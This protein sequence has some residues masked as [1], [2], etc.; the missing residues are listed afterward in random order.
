MATKH[1]FS[2]TEIEFQNYNRLVR[3]LLGVRIPV[4][5]VPEGQDDLGY[6]N[7]VPE[8][9]LAKQ[10]PIMKGLRN[11]NKKMFRM[12]VLAHE[13]LHQIFSDFS[14]LRK[15]QLSYNTGIEQRLFCTLFNI[16][17][18]SNIEYY[19]PNVIG[20][21]LL[22]A[23]RY[24][25]QHIYKKS[26][27]IDEGSKEPLTQVVN[28]LIQF[29]DM[30]SVKG[31]FSTPEAR[32]IFGKCVIV[33]NEG[34][35]AKQ[36]SGRCTAAKKMMEITKPLW[37]K[38]KLSE[39][40]Y[41]KLKKETKELLFD[42]G[43]DAIYFPKNGLSREKSEKLSRTSENDPEETSVSARRD[44]LAK[45]IADAIK[46]S[47]SD[48]KRDPIGEIDLSD[49]DPISS[50]KAEGSSD[51]GA[52]ASDASVNSSKEDS[53]GSKIQDALKNAEK[54]ESDDS[55]ITDK[56]LAELE[57]LEKDAEKELERENEDYD[58]GSIDLSIEPSLYAGKYPVYNKDMIP[59]ESDSSKYQSILDI[60][61][62]AIQAF[63]KKLARLFK[64][65]LDVKEHKKSG[66]LNVKRYS[67]S[68]VS[69]RIFDKNASPK[70]IDDLS[71]CILVDESGS[72]CAPINANKCRYE[73]ARETVI[74]LTETFGKLNIP[75]YVMGFSADSYAPADHYHYIKWKNSKKARL[76]LMQIDARSDNFDALSINIA[77]QMLKKRSSR[78]KLLIVISDGKPV[79]LS[80]SDSE[81]FVDAKEEIRKTR[82]DGIDVLGIAVGNSDTKAIQTLYGKN[83]FH[84]QD[85][86][87]VFSG[88]SKEITKIIQ[89]W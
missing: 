35:K 34:V 50:N 87:S 46:G 67:S 40:E 43:N 49:A 26:S 75:L 19:A 44:E 3:N 86:R 28:A 10:H 48:S 23:L 80:M 42:H 33:F 22:K 69:T 59:R 16:V 37:E 73:I 58:F 9:Y 81:A 39:E 14:L 85:V 74:C 70:D 13:T 65:D 36:P 56:D 71:V 1:K 7:D 53:L 32:E 54:A 18:D 66:K 62:T 31:E 83:F 38:D 52:G 88:A 30:G 68:R 45:Q 51:G 41:E 20:G 15:E 8:I 61:G 57:S 64:N 2:D 12:G 47:M 4:K 24:S 79:C 55:D 78:H 82:K 11:D 84:T 6:T 60:Y 29:G 76:A 63:S 72:M 17:E 77:H 25:I 21:V 89:S 5:P 27:K